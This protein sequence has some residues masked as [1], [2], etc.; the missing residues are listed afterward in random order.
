MRGRDA[1]RNRAE[2]HE[3]PNNSGIMSSDPTI[4]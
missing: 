4:Q 3:E 1:T 2:G